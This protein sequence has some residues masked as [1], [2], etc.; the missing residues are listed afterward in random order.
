MAD[1]LTL[2]VLSP[3]RRLLDSAV[4]TSVT[5]QGSE[6]QIQILPGHA[7]MV[8]TLETGIFTAQMQDGSAIRGVI[9]SGFFEVRDDVL[10]IIAETLETRDEIDL[11][12]AKLAQKKAEEALSEAGLDDVKFRKYQLKLQRSLIRQQFAAHNHD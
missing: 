6:G 4:A 11:N 10:T 2:N 12:R 5:L 1:T 9:S 3:E 7:A 8:G